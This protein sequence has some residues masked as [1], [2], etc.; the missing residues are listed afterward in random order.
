ML[1]M[2]L[3]FGVVVSL[4]IDTEFDGFLNCK[5]TRVAGTWLNSIPEQC[6]DGLVYRRQRELLSSY[7][8]WVLELR[9]LTVLW[10]WCI[11][12]LRVKSGSTFSVNGSCL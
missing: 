12:E 4:A 1:E 2:A 7:L 9:F 3:T 8:Q 11:A 10:K 6:Y 5:H